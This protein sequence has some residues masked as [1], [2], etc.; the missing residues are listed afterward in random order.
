MD[1]SYS[2]RLHLWLERLEQ[3]G[4]IEQSQRES[5]LS[6]EK[7]TPDPLFSGAQRPLVVAFFGGTGVGK[8]T[9]LNRLAGEPIAETGVERPTSREVTIYL[10]EALPLDSIERRLPWERIKVSQHRN[11]NRRAVVWIDMPDIDS[12]ERSNRELVLQCIPHVDVLIYVVSPERYRDDQEWQLLRKH[13]QR[14][15]WLFVMNHWDQGDEAQIGDFI[16]LLRQ[17]GFS[18]PWVLR[19]DS[20]D[21]LTRRLPDDFGKLEELIGR[22][23]KNHAGQK[24]VDRHAR[25]HKE[26]MRQRIKQLLQCL[27][28]AA[29]MERLARRWHTIWK[30]T[31]EHLQPSLKGAVQSLAMEFAGSRSRKR[32]PAASG[33]ALFLDLWARKHL[34]DAVSRLLLEAHALGVPPSPLKRKLAGFDERLEEILQEQ[35]RHSLRRALS[36]PGRS[37]QRILLAVF[38]GLR[39]LLPLAASGWVAWQVVI[40]YWRGFSGQG[41]Y[42]GVDFAVHS[43]LLIGLAWLIPF[44]FHRLLQPSL[45][46]AAATG[47]GRGYE[48]GLERIEEEVKQTLATLEDELKHF[49]DEGQRLLEPLEAPAEKHPSLD[50]DPLLARILCHPNDK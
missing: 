42:L 25:L 35:I 39:Y 23:E 5:I 19:C 26:S 28:E 2:K 41:E 50:Q 15:A 30:E 10:H 34:T 46:K 17:N 6:A 45:E 16:S 29:Q 18:D 40:G 24:L 31:L 21:D 37:W 22:L 1:S 11:D 13:T 3:Q 44:L 20:R 32:G 7:D 4:W 38:A 12:I 8:S 48:A 36:R 43:V 49:R 47:I 33:E 14:H 9:L 27:G